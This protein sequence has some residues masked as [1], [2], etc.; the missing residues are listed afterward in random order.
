ML[1]TPIRRDARNR[2]LADAPFRFHGQQIETLPGARCCSACKPMYRVMQ[3][4]LIWLGK[5][6]FSAKR[7]SCDHKN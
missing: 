7:D 6:A 3:M 5:I 4:R 1:P 2:E